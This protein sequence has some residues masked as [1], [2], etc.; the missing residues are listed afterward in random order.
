M[1]RKYVVRDESRFHFV[2]FTVIN[3]IDIFIRDQY[4]TIFLESV[5]YCQANKGLEVG[6]WCIMT[7]HIHMI[8]RS[9]GE[10]RLG[11]II[12]DLKAFTSRHI[13]KEMEVDYAESRKNWMMWMMKRAGDAKSNTKDFQLW[14]H[15]Y[16]PIELNSN[17]IM[18]NVLNYIHQNPVA[19]GLVDEAE[20]WVYSS[21]KDY[22]GKKGLLEL[23][24]LN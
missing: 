7:N 16:H 15:H 1:A 18:D 23:Y 24:F 6:A 21:A 19:M 14:Q 22:A 5:R 9:S 11:S 10:N 4:R 12:R 17:G 13:R 8:L 2:T 20:N 3:W